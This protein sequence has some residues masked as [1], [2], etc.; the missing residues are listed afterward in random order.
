[1][2]KFIFIIA[3][4]SAS[5]LPCFAAEVAYNQSLANTV[6][7]T[8]SSYVLDMSAYGIDAISMQVSISSATPQTQTFKDGTIS[9]GTITVVSTSALVATAASD[10][11]SITT[12]SALAPTQGSVSV[13]VSSA[14]TS[15]LS[16]STLTIAGVP[17]YPG[18]ASVVISS[19]AYATWISTTINATVPNVTA[20]VNPV[21]GSTVTITCVN[22]GAF[23]NSYTITSST[24]AL[25]I[26]TSTGTYSLS[27]KFTGGADS[28]IITIADPLHTWTFTQGQQW[29]VDTFSSNTAVSI[30]TAL[31]N[32]PDYFSASTQTATSVLISLVKAKSTGN[33]F[34][35]TVSTGALTIGSANFSGG[36]DNAFLEI[37]GRIL[38]QGSQWSVVG[39]SVQVSTSIAAAINSDS[40]L[41]GIMMAS[42]PTSCASAPSLCGIVYTTGSVVTSG[43]NNYSWSSSTPAALSITNSGLFGGTTSAYL[44]NT[45]KLVI[46]TNGYATGEA[47]KFTSGTV[48]ISPLVNQTT[49]YVIVVDANDIYLSNTSTGALAGT[50]VTLTSSSTTGP[51]TFTLSPLSLSGVALLTWSTSN[52]GMTYSTPTVTATGVSIP[53]NTLAT[54]WAPTIYNYDFGRLNYRYLRLTVTGPASAG[55]GGFN[56]VVT[57]YGKRYWR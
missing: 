13:Q 27:S 30:A 33:K 23:C 3:A 55:N 42:A 32:Y 49:Y 21:G 41:S 28:A 22:T 44:I 6:V 39:S 34:T 2:K 50:Y 57:G 7:T 46:P 4:L 9:T 19:N 47:V 38:T 18:T 37:N 52:D 1:M 10:T 25:Q 14:G 54:P 15:A 8:T 36:Q 48:T 29:F 26:I 20:A 56:T 12:N 16:F 40:V 31:S 24:V 11:V 5:A 45:P 51:H 35:L 43:S 17:I 53:V